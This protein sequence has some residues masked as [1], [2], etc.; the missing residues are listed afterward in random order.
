MTAHAEKISRER[1]AAGKVAKMSLTL[2]EFRGA[3]L[4]AQD[5]QLATAS[6]TKLSTRASIGR[7]RRAPIGSKITGGATK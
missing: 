2:A 1:A 6:V 7:N 5:Y 4:L 3:L